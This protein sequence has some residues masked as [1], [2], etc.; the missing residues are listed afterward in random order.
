[1]NIIWARSLVSLVLLAVLC[2]AVGVFVS[3]KAALTLAVLALLAQ[4]IFTN[5]IASATKLEPLGL[6]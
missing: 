6:G 4:G 5:A 2:A 3:T 1:M